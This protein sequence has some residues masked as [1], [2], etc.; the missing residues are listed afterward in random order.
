MHSASCHSESF[1]GQRILPYV[2]WAKHA[3]AECMRYVTG[4]PLILVAYS[5]LKGASFVPNICLDDD[6]VVIASGPMCLLLCKYA[7]TLARGQ[8]FSAWDSFMK[9]R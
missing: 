8:C 1:P 6:A 7:Q 2:T 3:I 9:S 5:V 4:T